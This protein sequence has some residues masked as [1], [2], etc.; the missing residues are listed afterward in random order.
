MLKSVYV[1]VTFFKWLL[2][3]QECSEEEKEQSSEPKK[4]KKK[5]KKNKKQ[6]VVN[7]F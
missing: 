2:N 4:R 6:K 1:S 3:M 5:K 7:Y